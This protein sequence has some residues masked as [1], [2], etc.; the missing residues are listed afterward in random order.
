MKPEQHIHPPRWA[1]TF[2]S[3][4]CRPEL[5]E[6][7]QGD[8]N[9][10]FD[11]NVKSKGVRKAKL[12]YVID[13]FKFLR[14]YTIRKPEFVNL[15]IQWIMIGSY[16][17][18]SGRKIMRNRLFSFINIVGL[19]LSM[20]VGLLMIGIL[21][22]VLSYDKFHNHSDRIYRVTSQRE[23]LDK[24]DR[25]PMATTSL[26][27][28]QEIS[29]NFSGIEKSVIL[30]RTFFGDIITADKTIPL[31]G[32]WASE[33]FFDFFSFNLLQGNPATVLKEPFSIVLTESSAQRLFGNDNALGKTVNYLDDLYT[34]TG[35]VQDAPKFSHMKFEMLGSL[36]TRQILYNDLTREHA[37]DN[38]WDTYIYV[39]LP[40]HTSPKT[41]YANLNQLSIKY[42]QTVEHTK[43]QLLLQPLNNIMISEDY[44]NQLGPTFGSTTLLIFIAFSLVVILSACFN[45]TNLSIARAL[46]RA[47]EIG[48]RKMI[49]AKKSSVFAQ[50]V[51]E[52][53]MISCIAL[54]F[55]FLLFFLLRS[56]LISLQSDLQKILVLNIS[57]QVIGYSVVFAITIGISAGVF[58]A[59]FFAKIDAINALKNSASVK[60]FRSINLRKALIV[61]QYSISI[62][63]ITSTLIML[64]QYSY[65]LAYDLGFSTENILNIKMQ[66]N[67]SDVLKKEL[68]EISEVKAIA[69]STMLPGVG[70]YWS[71]PLSY[72]PQADSAIVFYNTVDENY[73][74]L[75][76]H[77]FLAGRNFLT[78]SDSATETEII[79][80][81]SLLKRFNIAN[82]NPVDAV[83][84]V[85]ELGREHTRVTIIGVIKDFTYGKAD[86]H[87][88]Q[89]VI[90]R[91]SSTSLKYLNVSILSSDWPV[92]HAKIK[93]IWKNLDPVHP[94]EAKFYDAELEEAFSGLKASLK[95]GG[96]L[97]TL[98]ICIASLGLLGM[99]VFT[100][101]TRIKEI[102]LRKVL[103]ASEIKLIYLLGK[104]FFLLL[105]I[106][107]LIALPATYFVWNNVLLINMI[108][109][110]SIQLPE[111]FGG[112]IGIALIAAFMIGSQTLKVA[113]TNPAEVLKNE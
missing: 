29:E 47:R 60:L 33:S 61:F 17:K 99:I 35:V 91:Y 102:S 86:N 39:L 6:D 92:T 41:I 89:E 24:K 5:L 42:D 36:S 43:I 31:S 25:K 67:K 104:G 105:L 26:L 34:V 51:I 4:Y 74:P 94:L 77:L 106:A 88:S 66:G 70:N 97:A 55:S 12:I 64:K 90:F 98:A 7:L 80:N 76:K 54:V 13:V 101:E 100:T 78:K 27:A 10:Y 84:E 62:I 3:W 83:G 22:D 14:L 20:S 46:K 107:T 56:H 65:F 48:I 44:G 28:A 21:S 2:L 30:N 53:I 108:N 72:P 8:L 38:I 49:G 81:E 59:V 50:F 40:E 93:S 58:P 111:L 112:V 110:A 85:L 87:N 63:F 68:A 95:L 52:S 45:Y 18:T 32:L 71:I 82:Q 103:G 96:F 113:R 79:V 16:I 75:H 1:E 15:L 11:R 73:L 23:Y 9:E 19:S 109:H 69:K 37:W 57:P